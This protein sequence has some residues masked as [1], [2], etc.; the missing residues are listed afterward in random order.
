M[1]KMEIKGMSSNIAQLY[2]EF[3]ERTEKK[4]GMSQDKPKAKSK[5]KAKK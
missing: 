2:A 3:V 5:A 1:K 4:D